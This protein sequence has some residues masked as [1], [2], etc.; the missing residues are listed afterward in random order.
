M[1]HVTLELEEELLHTDENYESF[2]VPMSEAKKT[3][4]NLAPRVTDKIL[5]N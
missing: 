2:S 4:E 3:N 1:I 5:I